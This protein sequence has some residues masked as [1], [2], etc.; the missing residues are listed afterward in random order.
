MVLNG[1][2]QSGAR[3]PFSAN[4]SA[5]HLRNYDQNKSFQRDGYDLNKSS[6]KQSFQ[7]QGHGKNQSLLSNDNLSQNRGGYRISQNSSASMPLSPSQAPSR[8]PF[9]STAHSGFHS[10]FPAGNAQ[11]LFQHQHQQLSHQELRTVARDEP[12]FS[13][14]SGRQ[15]SAPSYE[16]SSGRSGRGLQHPEVAQI[17]NPFQQNFAQQQQ[18]HNDCGQQHPHDQYSTQGCHGSGTG[19]RGQTGLKQQIYLQQN[20]TRFGMEPHLHGQA[21]FHSQRFNTDSVTGMQA[22][23][24]IEGAITA[25]FCLAL[26][27]PIH[28]SHTSD[29]TRHFEAER[30]VGVSASSHDSDGFFSQLSEIPPDFDPYEDGTLFRAGFVS[31]TPPPFSCFISPHTNGHGID[32]R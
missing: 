5:P 30:N 24:V 9:V 27:N 10:S 12:Q 23:V 6:Q 26:P 19:N 28:Q 16:S 3:N 8:N 13:H 31:S 29:M 18:A 15:N 32:A 20:V 11:Q 2:A 14:S 7:M 22:S 25:D 4:Q 1:D 17:R 21:N